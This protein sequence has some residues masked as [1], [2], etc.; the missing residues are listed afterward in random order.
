[1]NWLLLFTHQHPDFKVPKSFNMWRLESLKKKK[2]MK[3]KIEFS[4]IIIFYRTLSA[5][6]YHLAKDY[7]FYPTLQIR[8]F[9]IKSFGLWNN[10]FA[11][12]QEKT[13]TKK[14]KH[15]E[16]CIWHF[17]QRLK[18]LTWKVVLIQPHTH[19]NE[20]FGNSP[21]I[22]YSTTRFLYNQK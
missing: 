17:S 16:N 6:F 21:K 11:I 15:K 5:Q 18:C 20:V 4:K 8:V 10:L 9:L 1:M 13:K 22:F 14:A 2:K 7:Q 12:P 19:T 3:V